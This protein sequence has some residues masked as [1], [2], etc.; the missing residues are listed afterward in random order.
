MEM[1]MGVPR[2]NT[3]LFPAFERGEG[4]KIDQYLQMQ[5]KP[6][7][8]ILP[9]FSSFGLSGIPT[10]DTNTKT[11]C[12]HKVSVCPVLCLNSCLWQ[13]SLWSCLHLKTTW[14]WS[15]KAVI[16]THL[17]FPVSAISIIP[18]LP[19]LLSLSFLLNSLQTSAV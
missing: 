1:G 16:D 11:F 3:A 15:R 6:V 8:L 9:T 7:S 5:E 10:S 13:L 2:L 17:H 18:P 12:S 14:P 19:C 4:Q